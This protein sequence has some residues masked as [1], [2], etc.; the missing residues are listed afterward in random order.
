[1]SLGTTKPRP[2]PRPIPDD[3]KA[4]LIVRLL[5]IVVG[6]AAFFLL[7]VEVNRGDTQHFDEQI[8]RSL[9]KPDDPGMPRG[10]LALREAARDVTSL[11][12]YALSTL[13][14]AIVTIFLACD[15][16][17]GAAR[18]LLTAVVSGWLLQKGLKA[19]I[20]RPRPSVV[21]HFMPVESTSFPSGHSMMSAIIFLTLGVILSRLEL[22][23]PH[24]R[25]Y[26]LSVAC[27][28]TGLVGLSRVYLGVHYPTDVLAG[29]TAGLVWAMLCSLVAQYLQR[30][31]TVETEL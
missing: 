4:L 19:L 13:L 12:G 30:R 20:A 22:K 1:V 7:A 9:R 17:K 15:G 2:R 25:I 31:G 27:L 24:L 8:L 10:P 28:L 5:I 3:G 29:W 26:F 14:V 11:G 23:R 21:P 6:I 18:F 16:K